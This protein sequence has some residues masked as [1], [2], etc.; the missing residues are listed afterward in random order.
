M[1]ATVNGHRPVAADDAVVQEIRNLVDLRLEHAARGDKANE[2]VL[3]KP[4]E[5]ARTRMVVEEEVEAWVARRA[6]SGAPPLARDMEQALAESVMAALAGIGK[7][8]RLLRRPDVEN[9]FIFGHNGVFLELWDGSV[10]QWPHPV[11]DSDN[12]LVELLAGMFARLGRTS[13]EFSASTPLGNL[14]LPAGGPLGARLAAVMEITE[15]PAVAIRLPRLMGATLD[16]LVRRGTIDLI[17]RDFLA[18]AVRARLKIAV[19]GE[20]GAGKTTLLRSLCHEIPPWEHVITIEDDYE[21]GLQTWPDRHPLVTAMEARLPNAEGVGEIT[22]DTLLKQ[23]LRHSPKRI[24][25]GEV[26]GGEVTALLRAL[27]TG[28]AGLCS[29]HADTAASVFDRIANMAQL[30]DPPLPVDA[31]YRWTASAIDLIVHIRQRD[32]ITPDG[33]RVRERYVEQVLEVGAVGDTDR[34]D[35]TEVFSPRGQD[36]RAVPAYVP[37]EQTLAALAHHGFAPELLDRPDGG[38]VDTH[39]TRS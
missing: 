23:A 34:P 36:G 32:T 28:A 29:F 30:A 6:T 13:R 12:H 17:L 18:A 24:V 38:W 7:I 8:D 20:W 11:A 21:L 10:E 14:H 9:I 2:Q 19:T 16:D 15:R 5:A 39:G 27:S 26:R 1:T 4:E 33:R 22:L 37:T 3:S 25:V 35:T 31:A